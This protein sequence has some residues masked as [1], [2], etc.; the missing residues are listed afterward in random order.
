MSARGLSGSGRANV[1]T[2]L[3]SVI[4]VEPQTLQKIR[5]VSG[6][7]LRVVELVDIAVLNDPY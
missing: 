3:S 1:A 7:V 2:V 6:F 4:S 5:P